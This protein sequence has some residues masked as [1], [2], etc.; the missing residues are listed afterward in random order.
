SGSTGRPKGVMVEHGGMWNHLCAKVEELGLCEEDRVAQNAPSSFDISVWQMMAPLMAGG[1]VEVI[2]SGTAEDAEELLGE[3]DR[4]ELT[5]IETA[6]AMLGALVEQ[7]ARKGD[8]KWG[9]KALRWMIS[10]AEA[11]PAHMCRGWK[12]LYPGSRL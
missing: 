2:E 4:R 6:P 12:E 5:V 10:N 9:L 8:R 7:E 11:L 1:R 3:A